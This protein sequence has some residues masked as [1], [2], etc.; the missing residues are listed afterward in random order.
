MFRM[1]PGKILESGISKV[2]VLPAGT[3]ERGVESGPRI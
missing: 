3:P 1:V 2:K